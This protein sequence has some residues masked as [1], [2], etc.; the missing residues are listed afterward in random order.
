MKSTSQQLW[1]APATQGSKRS[2]MTLQDGARVAVLGGGP[3]GSFFSSALL[4]YANLRGLRL[5]VDVYEPREFT[6]AGPKGCNMCGGI[7][8][9]SLV[10]NLAVDGIPLPGKVVQRGIDS[11][12]M[13]MDRQAVRIATPQDEKR[14]A[15]VHRGAGPRDLEH[16]VWTSFDGHLQELSKQRGVTIVQ[17]R[18]VALSREDGCIKVQSK[19][20]HEGSYDLLAVA[21]GVNSTAHRLIEEL[22][23]SYHPPRSVKTSIR[24]Y[25]LGTETIDRHLGSSMHVFLL[26]I[27]G[28]D[29]AAMIPKGEYVTMCLLGH[30]IDKGLLDEFLS[31]PE[32]RSCMP[33]DWD[34][35]DFSCQCSPSMPIIGASPVCMDRIVFIGDCGVSRLYKDGIGAAFRTAKAAARTAVFHGVSQQ[36]FTRHY[37]PVC[38]SIARDNRVGKFIFWVT[39][40]IQR[41]F[42][43][44]AVILHAV[45]EEQ[46]K[47]GP[48]PRMSSVLW[49]M[50]TGSADYL[51]IFRRTLHPAFLARLAHSAAIVIPPTML[52]RTRNNSRK[53]MNSQR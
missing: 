48:P 29:F 36:Q 16:A 39:H 7:I 8:S 52:N 18:V 12:M 10:Q 24:E 49:D 22:E 38:R 19:S 45:N 6:C 20:G 31:S 44:R 40:L 9:E 15:T 51:E 21:S 35:E 34:P 14:I 3:A 43:A 46:S 5:S 26:D 28:L 53:S 33:E 27:P 11:Y 50:F 37:E 23:P 1:S 25:R 42:L 17:D 47:N 32:L 4:E 2:T 41:S 13:H 30:K